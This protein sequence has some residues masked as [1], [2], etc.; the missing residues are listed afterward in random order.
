MGCYELLYPR[1]AFILSCNL[2]VNT[3]I[4]AGMPFAPTL[5]S[6]I[7]R[8]PSLDNDIFGSELGSLS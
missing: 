3:D 8:C 2:L 7:D 4:P 1:S 6:Q 5:Y